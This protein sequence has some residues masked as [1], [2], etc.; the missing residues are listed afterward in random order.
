MNKN[1]IRSKAVKYID[2]QGNPMPDHDGTVIEIENVGFQFFDIE[3]KGFIHDGSFMELEIGRKQFF[4]GDG[5]A[6]IHDG[7]PIELPDGKMQYFDQNGLAMWPVDEKKLAPFMT[8]QRDLFFDDRL[9]HIKKQTPLSSKEIEDLRLAL[10]AAEHPDYISRPE[11]FERS[12][13]M[14]YLTLEPISPEMF[15]YL[16]LLKSLWCSV[17]REYQLRHKETLAARFILERHKKKCTLASNSLSESIL[18]I[19]LEREFKKA[20]KIIELPSSLRKIE[21]L[22]TTESGLFILDEKLKVY[23]Q[24]FGKSENI[25]PLITQLDSI[26]SH[27]HETRIS[28]IKLWQHPLFMYRCIADI[29][30]LDR[31]KSR[32]ELLQKKPPALTYA[33]NEQVHRPMCNGAKFDQGAGKI[34]DRRGQELAIIDMNESKKILPSMNIETIQKILRPE[35][36]K[37]LSTV[38]A[39]RLLRWEIQTVTKQFVE[40]VI[41]ARAL[42]VYGGYQELANLLGVGNNKKAAEQ[43]RDIIVWQAAPRFYQPN[44]RYGN[45]L[46]FDYT[47]SGHGRQAVLQLVLGNMMLPHYVYELLNMPQACVSDR[48][49]IPIVNMPPLIGRP[50]DQGAQPSYQM[51][52]LVEMRKG[53]KEFA[54]NGCV[55][56][57]KNRLEELAEKAGLSKRLFL[58]VIDRWL[59]DG[60]DAPAFLKMVEDDRYALGNHFKQA[61]DFIIEAGKKEITMSKAGKKSVTKRNSG[62]FKD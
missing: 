45:M 55:L 3:G 34:I 62:I 46:S 37:V 6:I 54:S 7:S 32:I 21:A 30:W 41:D 47:P 12:P 60:T 36:I 57:P 59:Q 38:N 35:N 5:T 8:K 1:P 48:R 49:L 25:K 2:Y 24:Q 14:E 56:I 9:S 61:Q 39:H 15:E 10:L 40:G 50:N 13:E 11:G 42:K 20:E 23:Y 29:V 31:I 26:N 22:R 33:V 27:N 18:A 43:L 58:K 16:Y 44:G 17:W 4:M 53:A 19:E 28:R 51:E 52:I